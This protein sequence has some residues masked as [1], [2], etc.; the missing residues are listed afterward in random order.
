MSKVLTRD[1]EA[2]SHRLDA[3][4]E[5]VRSMPDGAVIVDVEAGSV[6]AQAGV[7]TL[8]VVTAVNGKRVADFEE[9]RK[10]C[11]SS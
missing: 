4:Q 5:Q 1:A 6:A 3:I 8:D 11:I 7:R 10:I 2:I 9:F